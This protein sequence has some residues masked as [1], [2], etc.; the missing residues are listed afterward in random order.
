[1][2]NFHD[3]FQRQ[4]IYKNGENLI[5]YTNVGIFYYF[6]K[7]SDLEILHFI[8]ILWYNVRNG[9]VSVC[10]IGFKGIYTVVTS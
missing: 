6:N 2:N 7:K 10:A 9:I 3:I 5:K 1:M 8:L 4:Y